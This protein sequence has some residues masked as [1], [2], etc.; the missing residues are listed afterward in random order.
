M[1]KDSRPEFFIIVFG[2]IA[3]MVNG[4]VMPVFAVIYSQIVQTFQKTDPRVSSYS[5]SFVVILILLIGNQI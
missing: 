5:N 1:I 4:A 3:C 2:L